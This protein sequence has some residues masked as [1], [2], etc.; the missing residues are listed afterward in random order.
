MFAL[1]CEMVLTKAGSELARVTMV[2]EVGC[3]L[4]DKLVKPH[5]PVED[6][7]TR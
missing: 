5:N 2:D 6:Y 1:D 4:L 3:V 7:L